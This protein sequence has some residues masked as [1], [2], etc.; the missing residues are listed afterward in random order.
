MKRLFRA[1]L[2]GQ[3]TGLVAE[4]PVGL[5]SCRAP[6]SYWWSQ[7]AAACSPSIKATGRRF[8]QRSLVV[9]AG[10][11]A[12]PAVG[13]PQRPG[14]QQAARPRAHRAGWCPAQYLGCPAATPKALFRGTHVARRR[15]MI[16]HFLFPLPLS[17]LASVQLKSESQG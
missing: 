2:I 1:R 11:C 6:L 15:A 8:T 10:R 9:K 4:E 16:Y 14:A 17:F 7:H 3:A 5:R 12:P 13:H